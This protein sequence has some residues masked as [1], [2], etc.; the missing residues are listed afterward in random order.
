MKFRLSEIT[1]FGLA[2][3]CERKICALKK[4]RYSV[5][6]IHLW[7]NSVKSKNDNSIVWISI[8]KHTHANFLVLREYLFEFSSTARAWAVVMGSAGKVGKQSENVSE[9]LDTTNTTVPLFPSNTSY[10]PP[11]FTILF[12]SLPQKTCTQASAEE[13]YKPF[14]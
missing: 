2:A 12:P 1:D 6:E 10:H 14:D 8:K 13:I 5:E 3:Y 11:R 7:A 4:A 9:N